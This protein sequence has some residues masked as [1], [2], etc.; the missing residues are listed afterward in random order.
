MTRLK[1]LS[2]VKS[3]DACIFRCCQSIYQSEL[4]WWQLLG[5]RPQGQQ[6][7]LTHFLTN[8]ATMAAAKVN[9]NGVMGMGHGEFPN[10]E[11]YT[12]NHC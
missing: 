3:R 12:N 6:Q 1:N 8:C 10:G 2:C 4:G 11:H 7:P 5:L 9:M